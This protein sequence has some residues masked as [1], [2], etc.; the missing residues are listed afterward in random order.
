MS[1][2]ATP[3]ASSG[4][5][6]ASLNGALLIVEPTE[7]VHDIN[8]DYGTTNAVR[9]NVH[10]I[11]GEHAGT[12]YDDTLVFPKVLQS[13]LSSR[14]GQKVLGRLGQG[15]A[16]KGQSPPWKLEPGD[17]DDEKTAVEWL[18]RTQLTAA[19]LVPDGTQPF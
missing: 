5:E 11:D 15:Q 3:A 12:T 9:A 19:D 7:V 1:T 4:I 8:T 18:A 6:W 17:S 13:Q 14:V 2:F 10:V 16:K